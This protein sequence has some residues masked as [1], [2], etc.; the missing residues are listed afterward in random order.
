[1]IYFNSILCF[2]ITYITTVIINIIPLLIYTSVVVKAKLLLNVF[3]KQMEML[4]LFS[5]D[6][7]NFT[8]KLQLFQFQRPT[9]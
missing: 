6:D 1:M 3:Q 8:L 7:L 9:E 4:H 2:N 5:D